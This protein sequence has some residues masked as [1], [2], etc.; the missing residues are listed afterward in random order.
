[1]SEHLFVLYADNI[2]VVVTTNEEAFNYCRTSLEA[3]GRHVLET[4]D[5]LTP[6]PTTFV[7]AK[8]V[9]CH[10]TDNLKDAAIQMRE[11]LGK[12]MS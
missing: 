5:G 3:E 1:M 7:S 10:A 2:P 12:A 9:D 6:G 11:I 4:W 8:G